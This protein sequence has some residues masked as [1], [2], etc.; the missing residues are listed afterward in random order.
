MGRDIIVHAVLKSIRV[1]SDNELPW[2]N[3]SFDK[4]TV[5]DHMNTELICYSDPHVCDKFKTL[6]VSIFSAGILIDVTL[7]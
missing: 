7:L 6:Q 5:L 1:L 3:G 4:R 2:Y